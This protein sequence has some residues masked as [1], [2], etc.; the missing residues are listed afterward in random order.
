MLLQRLLRKLYESQWVSQP[1]IQEARDSAFY[2]DEEA[3]DLTPAVQRTA[4]RKSV[5]ST[6][7]SRKPSRAS[8]SQPRAS[9]S[10]GQSDRPVKC[11]ECSGY[12]LFARDCANR[13]HR[14]TATRLRTQ[15]FHNQ[16][17][18]RVLILSGLPLITGKAYSALVPSH[19][20]HLRRLGVMHCNDVCV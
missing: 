10:K 14:Q 6:T 20:P 12:G 15:T 4:A 1:E 8:R 7:Q 3:A 17:W 9:T 13:P 16:W 5:E 18:L 19:F 11:Y 2:L